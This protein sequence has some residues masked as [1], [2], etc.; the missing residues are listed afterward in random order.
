MLFCY[1]RNRTV[2]RTHIQRFDNRISVE[3]LEWEMN[4]RAAITDKKREIW[5]SSS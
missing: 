4:Q 5:M 2:V 1:Q 3:I